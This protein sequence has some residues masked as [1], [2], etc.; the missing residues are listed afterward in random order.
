MVYWQTLALAA[1]AGIS[2]ANA[3]KSRYPPKGYIAP[4]ATGAD[5]EK[6]FAKAKALVSQ[7]TLEEKLNLTVSGNGVP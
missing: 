7:M 6:A 5:Q 4:Y 1:S 3:F 2:C